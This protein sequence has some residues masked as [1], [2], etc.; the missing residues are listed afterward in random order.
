MN[1]KVCVVTGATAGIGEVTAHSLAK[2]GATVVIIGRSL[3]RCEATA[4]RIRQDSQNPGVDY[5]VADLSSQAEVRRVAGEF[6]QKYDRLDVLVN[7]AGG[8]F[9]RRQESVDGI[10]MTWA[11]NHLNYF[12]LTQLL[13]DT[14]LASTPRGLSMYHPTRI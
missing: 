3:E 7:N 5:L 4:T 6:C 2:Q 8:F 1:G 14:I 12:L 10:E 11:L 9:R 13:L